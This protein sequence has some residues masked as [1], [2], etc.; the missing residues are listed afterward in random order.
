MNGDGDHDNDDGNDIDDDDD[1][2]DD[3]RKPL[4]KWS[5]LSILSHSCE[6]SVSATHLIHLSGR[7]LQVCF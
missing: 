5:P 7:I 3:A 4:D 6:I 1:V 2:G